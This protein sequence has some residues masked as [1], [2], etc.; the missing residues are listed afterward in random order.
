MVQ[1][2]EIILEI[3]SGLV[4]FSAL[5]LLFGKR[6]K[7]SGQKLPWYGFRRLPNGDID[8][9]PELAAVAGL[10]LF[11]VLFATWI[12]GKSMFEPAANH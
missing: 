8:L 4:G 5:C 3:V 12:A 11:V 10:I 1:V 9:D 2:W 7:F 6:L